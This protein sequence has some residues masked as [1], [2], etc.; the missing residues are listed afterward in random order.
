LVPEYGKRL[1][2]RGRLGEIAP[3]GWLTKPGLLAA[4]VE[5]LTI[6]PGVI[7]E[8]GIGYGE[9]FG[10]G[11]F[12]V[13]HDLGIAGVQFFFHYF[14]H[15]PEL[16]PG[17]AGAVALTA[18]FRHGCLLTLGTGDLFWGEVF[19]VM[20]SESV[21]TGQPWPTAGR[22]SVAGIGGQSWP[23]SQKRTTL[24]LNFV[25]DFKGRQ[26]SHYQPTP[27]SLKKICSAVDFLF[28]KFG[29][30]WPLPTG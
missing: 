12:L 10:G 24:L 6:T 23:G 11:Q 7:A 20:A 30:A 2:F 8:S 25:L 14:P 5:T 19:A 27:I 21:E 28:L 3:A 16:N 15:D 17:L 26:Q 29:Q 1:G 4:A 9:Q 22:I 13:G 18:G